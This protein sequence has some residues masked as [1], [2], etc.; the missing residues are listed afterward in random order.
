MLFL[1]IES[2][3]MWVYKRSMF[4][5][6]LP[7]SLKNH[8]TCSAARIAINARQAERLRALGLCSQCRRSICRVR[9]V[10]YSLLLV[11]IQPQNKIITLLRS[12][13]FLDYDLEAVN[14]QG[15]NCGGDAFLCTLFVYQVPSKLLS[16]NGTTKWMVCPLIGHG[17]CRWAA[18]WSGTALELTTTTTMWQLLRTVHKPMDEQCTGKTL[19]REGWRMVEIRCIRKSFGGVL[20]SPKM[21]VMVVLEM[22]GMLP[23][24]AE[25]AEHQNTWMSCK[26]LL[27]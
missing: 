21:L 17:T 2:S 10:S 13:E 9:S 4:W 25:S 6:R 7:S 12:S 14:S 26:K 15:S 1:M 5:S 20:C 16:T 3:A 22:N 27:T 24:V 8:A 11:K 18:N 19:Q 23:F